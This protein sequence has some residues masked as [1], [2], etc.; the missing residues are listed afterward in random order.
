MNKEDVEF[1]MTAPILMTQFYKTLLQMLS[2]TYTEGICK[3]YTIHSKT[4]I[5]NQIFM[6]SRSVF[7]F[8]F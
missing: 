1:L 7:L 8:V 2:D 3:L 6:D 4:C 5:D